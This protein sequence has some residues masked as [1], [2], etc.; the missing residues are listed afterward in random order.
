M[1]NGFNA[2][3][4]DKLSIHE[5]DNTIAI[6]HELNYDSI[7]I[8]STKFA[9][10]DALKSHIRELY[11][12]GNPIIVYYIC[13]T[14]IKETDTAIAIDSYEDITIVYSD[15]KVEPY[16]QAAY[17]ANIWGLLEEQAERVA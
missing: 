15:S 4:F 16:I 17:S 12:S 14:P 13:T 1:S 6:E 8:Y 10:V 5:A 3:S 7:S 9:S 2:T 11:T